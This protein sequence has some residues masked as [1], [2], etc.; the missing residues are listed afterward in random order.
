[1][2]ELKPRIG[3]DRGSGGPA[4]EDFTTYARLAGAGL[5]LIIVF[6]GLMFAVKVFGAWSSTNSFDHFSFSYSFAS[7]DNPP[8][9]WVVLYEFLFR[10]GI[11]FAE[12]CNSFTL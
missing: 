3:R 2:K 11:C 1:M 10:F 8:V 6:V 12:T 5:G 4:P 9:H 7:T